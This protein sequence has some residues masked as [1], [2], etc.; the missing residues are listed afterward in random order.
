GVSSDDVAYSLEASLSGIEM[1]QYREDDS[2][3]PV[4]LRTVEA[5]RESIQKLDGMTV[6]AQSSGQTVP[7]RQVADVRLTFEPGKIER[8][9]RERTLT[10][11]AQ[12]DPATSA[13]EVNTVLIP[14]LEAL[15]D[16]WPKGYGFELGGE[17]ESSGDANAAIADK[18]P[19]ALMSILLLLV[20]QFNSLRRPVIVLTTI[21]LGLIGVTIGLLLA[22]SAFGFFTILGIIS[23]A[24][25][26]INN[27]IVLL[28]RIK[29]QLADGD[30]HHQAIVNA[31]I[32]R[33]RPIMLTTGTTVLGMMPLWWGGTAMFR[34]MAVTI[35]FGLLFATLLTLLVVPVM[36][37][38]F[39]RVKFSNQDY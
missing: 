22:N 8:R 29:I 26:I 34:P 10:L 5:D 21:P 24:G 16:T 2:L 14:Q 18:L 35:I 31:C 37:S 32:Q 11:Q 25:I 27:A 23:L 12:L 9:D 36:Y 39:F 33:L 3:I 17:S 13:A 1:T 4:T 15:A 6:Y 30:E 38:A 20:I 28:D 7:L 19:L